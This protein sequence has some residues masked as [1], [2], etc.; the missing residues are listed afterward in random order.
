M[1]SPEEKEQYLRELYFS[2]ESPAAYFGVKKIWEQY[3]ETRAKLDKSDKG[4]KPKIKYE[5]I[6]KFLDN[7][8]TY[9]LHKPAVKKFTFRKT[10]VSYSDQQWQADLVDMQKFVKSN[11]GYK[12]ILTVVDIFSRYAWAFPLKSKRGEEVKDLFVTIF[13][14]AKPEKIQIGRASCRERV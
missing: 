13:K 10:M 6:K 7:L 11:K 3:R 9:Q 5:E 8:P 2:P 14:E 12:Y 1:S 4:K